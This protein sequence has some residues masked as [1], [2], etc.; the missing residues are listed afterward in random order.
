M[1]PDNFSRDAVR[2]GAPPAHWKHTCM[3]AVRRAGRAQLA[4]MVAARFHESPGTTAGTLNDVTSGSIE[5][6]AVSARRFAAAMM[7]ALA[8]LSSLHVMDLQ[9]KSRMSGGHGLVCG[10]Q[11]TPPPPCWAHSHS[12]GHQ[13][14]GRRM[15]RRGVPGEHAPPSGAFYGF[16]A[17]TTRAE[18]ALNPAESGSGSLP[19]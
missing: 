8:C 4:R 9:D 15:R 6:S 19:S 16:S 17:P 7:L 13:A 12:G 18:F 11:R 3:R 5:T 14:A 2:S 10:E 1:E